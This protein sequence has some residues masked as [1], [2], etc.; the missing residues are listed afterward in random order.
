MPQPY[1]HGTGR[2]MKTM[3]QCMATLWTNRVQHGF[4]TWSKLMRRPKCL[5]E[6]ATAYCNGIRTWNSLNKIQQKLV[7]TYTVCWPF[8]FFDWL[9]LPKVK[10]LSCIGRPKGTD[11]RWALYRNSMAYCITK[12]LYWASKGDR[13]SLGPVS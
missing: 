10:Q 2:D 3:L 8:N 12:L 4:F 11:I 13:Y 6:W 1:C 7:P 5:L 9:S